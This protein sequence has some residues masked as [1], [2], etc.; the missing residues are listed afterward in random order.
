[1]MEPRVVQV[2]NHADSVMMEK[3]VS[4]KA[5]LSSAMCNVSGMIMMKLVWRWH[6]HL[7]VISLVVGCPIELI[8]QSLSWC[9][10][11][12]VYWCNMLEYASFQSYTGQRGW[13]KDHGARV[14]D[15]GDSS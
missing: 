5:M 13:S 1:V 9:S 11:F 7:A 15:V 14:G 12:L 6:S 10:E 2:F 4:C 3:A 8:I